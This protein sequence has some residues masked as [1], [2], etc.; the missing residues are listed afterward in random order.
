MHELKWTDICGMNDTVMLSWMKVESIGTLFLD[1]SY[2]WFHLFF[3]FFPQEVSKFIWIMWSKNNIFLLMEG[4]DQ[5]WINIK[6]ISF[7]WGC[8]ILFKE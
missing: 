4:K 1:W 6:C 7:V 5:V 8:L 3:L 2:L